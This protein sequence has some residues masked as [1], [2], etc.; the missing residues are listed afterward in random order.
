MS[1]GPV[2]SKLCLLSQL[3]D[4]PVG[5]KVRFLGCVI[6][7]DTATACLKLGHMYPPGTNETVQVDIELVLETIQPGLTQVGQW[8][9]VVGYIREGKGSPVHVQALLAWLTGPLDLGRY[10]KNLQ[11]QVARA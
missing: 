10:E 8:V 7:Y 9:N 1:W 2:P 3:Q 6:S 4:V 11:D 5:D